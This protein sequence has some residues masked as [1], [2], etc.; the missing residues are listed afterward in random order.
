MRRFLEFAEKAFTVL[1]LLH[2]SGGPLVVILMDGFS[3][4]E[5][6]GAPSPQFDFAL[7]QLG[8]LAI[9]AVTFFLLILRGKRAAYLLT[10]DR[11]IWLLVGL[12]IASILWSYAPAI[13]QNRI[14]ALFGTTLFGFYL[15]SRYSLKEQLRLLGWTF[16]LALILSLLFA[17]GVPKY[18]IMGGVHAGAWRGI[19]PHK[20]VFGKVMVTSAITFL[21]LNKIERRHHWLLWGAF[22]TSVSFLVLAV[23]SS[24]LVN[25]VLLVLAYAAFRTFRLRYNLMVL[26]LV[27][28]LLIGGGG[29]VWIV[30]HAESILSSMGRDLTLTG[31]TDLWPMVW[32]S[33]QNNFWLGHGYGGFWNGLNGESA[34]IW[35]Q[36]GWPVPNAHNGFLDLW[37]DLGLVG[38]VLFVIGFGQALLKSLFWVRFSRDPEVFWPLLYLTYTVL[39]NL[40]ETTLM[41][42]NSIDW[43]LYVAAYLSMLVIRKPQQQLNPLEDSA[44]I[45]SQPVFPARTSS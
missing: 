3:E 11:C 18:G 35:R 25:F 40:T 4:G 17:V 42:R 39:N 32:D 13:T 8:F 45:Y 2:Y 24:A 34:P 5:L 16:G 1:A 9:Y 28:I 30:T 21:L 41:G 22:M 27:S 7:V 20:N 14:I 43:V 37:I 23:S 36:L 19:Y 15:A 38:V 26:A 10:K 6:G 29:A 31:R 44:E 33:I 12:A